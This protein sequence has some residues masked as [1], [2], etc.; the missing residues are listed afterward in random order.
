METKNKIIVSSVN[1]RGLSINHHSKLMNAFDYL[2]S[3]NSNIICLQETHWINSDIRQLKKYTNYDILINGEFTNK[4][5]V[6]TLIAKNFEYKIL[7]TI[8]DEE[9][10]VLTLDLLIENDFSIRLINIYAPNNDTPAFY[11]YIQQLHD[12]SDCTYIIIT[13]DFN[14]VLDPLK[15]SYNY[16]NTNNPK[17]REVILNPLSNYNM[18]DIYRHIHPNKLEYTWKRKNPSKKARLDYFIISSSLSDLIDKTLIILTIDWTDHAFIQLHIIT[19]TFI[20]GKGTW[21]LNC[22]LLYN[23]K[24][25]KLVNEIIEKIKLEY[26]VPIYNIDNIKNIDDKIVQFTISDKLF[27]EM[28]LL[29]VRQETIHFASQY[30]KS[31]INKKMN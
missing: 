4:R 19:N 31:I 21:K 1:C 25:I 17:S 14:L 3:T 18:I 6:A 11:N 26:A 8:C 30:K 23:E 24:Y 12:S 27:L 28:L 7:N 2:K 9:S 22:N 20:R 10:R 16:S 29:K 5:D 15:D 13:E